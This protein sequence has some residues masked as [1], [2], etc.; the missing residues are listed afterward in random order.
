MK[1][2]KTIY[3]EYINADMI[4]TIALHDV[5]NKDEEEGLRTWGIFAYTK[6]GEKFLL[7]EY[8]FDHKAAANRLDRIAMELGAVMPMQC[9]EDQDKE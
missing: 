5:D 7:T 3:N 1:F 6:D 8:E 2:I 4:A 9:G